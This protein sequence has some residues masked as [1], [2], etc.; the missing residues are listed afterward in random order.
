LILG[1]DSLGA[2]RKQQRGLGPALDS[3]RNWMLSVYGLKVTLTNAPGIE[4]AD[5]SVRLICF[6]AIRELLLNAA[7]H[8]RSDNVAVT[9]TPEANEMLQV[10]VADNGVGFDPEVWHD[11]TGLLNIQRRLEM[12]GGSLKI[13]SRMNAGTV[14]TLHAP[15]GTIRRKRRLSDLRNH[16]RIIPLPQRHN[17]V[18]NQSTENVMRDSTK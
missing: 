7:K 9:L 5:V 6:N 17:N 14:T 4:P 1:S 12:V 10:V 16:G 15:L 2:W 13:E 11:G 18:T 3:L 8:A